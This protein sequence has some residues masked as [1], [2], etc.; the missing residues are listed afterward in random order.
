KPPALPERR[1]TS[2]TAANAARSTQTS[3][4]PNKYGATHCAT[5]SH[6]PTEKPP[7]PTMPPRSHD[8]K[9][10]PCEACPCKTPLPGSR[11]SAR[12]QSKHGSTERPA[13]ASS[14]LPT[15]RLGVTPGTAL[16]TATLQA[17]SEIH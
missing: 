7:K 5:S 17:C 13:R 1:W 16:R 8:K 15:I 9:Q 12:P 2:D 6:T 3:S 4:E 14:T 11:P 10:P